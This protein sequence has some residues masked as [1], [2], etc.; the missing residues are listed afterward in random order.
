MSNDPTG[1][2]E[3]GTNPAAD[4]SAKLFRFPGGEAQLSDWGP[5]IV[6]GR[7]MSKTKPPMREWLVEG[8]IPANNVTLLYGDGGVGKSLLGYQLAIAVASG[9]EWVSFRPTRGPVVYLSAEDEKDEIHRRQW[10]IT[11][12]TGSTPDDLEHLHLLDVSEG[13]A[14]LAAPDAKEGIKPTMLW[15]WLV[16]YVEKVRPA[17]LIVDTVT[18]TFDGEDIAKRDARKFVRMFRELAL[19]RNV[20]VVLLAH[21]SQSGVSSGRGTSG[22]VAWSN[23]ARSRLYLRPS[24]VKETAKDSVILETK[25]TNRSKRGG[26]IILKWKDWRFERVALPLPGAE[27]AAGDPVAAE[28]RTKRRA[29]ERK[30]E[31]AGKAKRDE[32][33]DRTAIEAALKECPGASERQLAKMTGIPRTPLQRLKKAAAQSVNDGVA[34]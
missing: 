18:E 11:K 9:T 24:K 14:I 29:A 33:A 27:M 3:P 31:I 15:H 32:A 2:S 34:Q 10:D 4:K 8:L 6:K 26:K 16:D 21:P 20:T 17:L 13:G 30:R 28:P 12:G 5:L 1:S 7:E 22:S 19:K 25:K 23:A